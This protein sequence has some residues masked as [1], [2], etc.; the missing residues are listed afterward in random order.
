MG[1]GGFSS[2]STIR[3][4]P[5]VSK[6]SARR[7]ALDGSCRT[8]IAGLAE[9]DGDLLVLEGLL[10]KPDGS[11]EIRARCAG[12]VGDAERLGTEL[13][14]ELRRRAGSGFGLD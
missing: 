14:G 2:R 1:Y 12:G 6:P 3:V 4:V 13:G 7:A 11:A 8:P 9:L 10:L 5:L